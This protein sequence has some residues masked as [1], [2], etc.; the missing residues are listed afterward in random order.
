MRNAQP[1]TVQSVGRAVTILEL[2]A[3]GAGELG[4]TELGRRLGVHKATASRLVATLAEHGLVEQNP[5]TDKYRL[6]FGVVRLAAV[7][8]AGLD[9]VRQARPV[10]ERL[11][12]ETGETVNLAVLD[13][14]RVVNIDQITAPHLVVNVNWVGK[15]TPLHCSSNGKVLLAGLLERERARLLRG[16]LERLTPHTITDRDLLNA[17]LMEA[18]ARGYAYTEEELEI[19]LNAVAAPIRDGA[20]SVVAAVSVSGPAYRLTPKRM[21]PVGGQTRE[22]GAE[23][24]RRMG[25]VEEAAASEKRLASVVTSLRRGRERNGRR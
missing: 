10:L 22:A 17:Q 2:L 7:A 1:A 24:S 16:R 20:G 15:R 25:F 11:A 3:S 18:G 5:V 14:D 19:G 21:P 9:L 6:G 13:G 12:E 4:V 8:T 23:I